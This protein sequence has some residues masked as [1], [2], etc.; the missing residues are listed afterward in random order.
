VS[1]KIFP[2]IISRRNFF[3]GIGGIGSRQKIGPGC[4][5]AAQEVIGHAPFL[6][7]DVSIDS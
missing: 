7:E 1:N 3:S 2:P 4:R 5:R 6:E